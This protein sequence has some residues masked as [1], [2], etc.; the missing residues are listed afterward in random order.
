LWHGPGGFAVIL[1]SGD[2][3]QQRADV[4]SFGGGFLGPPHLD[5][6]IGSHVRTYSS[7]SPR[8][9]IGGVDSTR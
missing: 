5:I 7:D 3:Q 6:Y 1:Q 9:R 2:A 8:N 4:G